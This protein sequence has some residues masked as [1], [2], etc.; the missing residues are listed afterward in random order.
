MPTFKQAGRFLTVTTPLG[1]DALLAVGLEGTEALSQ[2]FAF[3]LDLIAENTT[4]VP[5]D[6]V[7]GRAMTAALRLEDGSLRY[8]S[9]VCARLSRGRRDAAVYRLP[10]RG[11]ARGLVVDEAVA[12]PGVSAGRGA[13]DPPAG[14]RGAGYGVRVV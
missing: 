8:F 7:L 1:P 2:L 9:G 5:F 6:A 3:R 13:G 11:H 4:T 12:L 10:R 14:V